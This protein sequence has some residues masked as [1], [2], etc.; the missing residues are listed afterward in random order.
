MT[1]INMEKSS[2]I[3]RKSIRDIPDFPKPGIV[4]KDITTLLSD[5]VA[6]SLSIDL[7]CQKYKSEKI[8]FVVV[9]ESRGFIFGAPVAVALGAGLTLV[10]KPG[11]LPAKTLSK[12]YELEY[13]ADTLCIHED[14]FAGIDNPKVII[15]D[16]LIATGGSCLATAELVRSLGAT[17]VGAA[18]VIELSF[19]PGRQKL[20][21]AGIDVYSLISY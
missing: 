20:E 13:G 3:L 17:L 4:F 12:T 10:R 18:F 8:D 7:I 9:P 21:S 6:F 16:D 15:V 2:E 19:L 5:P 1:V 14:A 11:K